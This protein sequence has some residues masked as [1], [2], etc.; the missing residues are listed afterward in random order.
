MERHRCGEAVVIPI[1]LRPVYF[2]GT[3]FGKLQALPTDAKPITG[4]DW[5]SLDIAFYDVAEGIRKCVEIML[6]RRAEPK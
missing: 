1:L 3:P 6:L 4:P 2:E 5:Y